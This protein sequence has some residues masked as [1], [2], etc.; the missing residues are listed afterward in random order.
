MIT[1]SGKYKFPN[2]EKK[3][4]TL[5][6]YTIPNIGGTCP[7][8]KPLIDQAQYTKT[9]FDSF[10]LV[11]VNDGFS[12]EDTF[13]FPNPAT[14][15]LCFNNSTSIKSIEVFSVDGKRITQKNISNN[16]LNVE[17]LSRGLYYSKLFDEYGKV[18]QAKFVKE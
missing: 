7:D 12:I 6:S 17:S 1:S 13:V 18:Y 8:I 10:V 11:D 14:I 5:G 9:F 15:K 16:C 2:G 3:T 4:W